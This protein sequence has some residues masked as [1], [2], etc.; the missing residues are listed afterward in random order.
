MA[1][2]IGISHETGANLV[3]TLERLSDG[4]FWNEVSGAWQAAPTFADKSIALT[5]GSSENS[6]HYT[7]ANTGSLGTP[8]RV[9]VRVHDDGDTNNKTIAS[10]E[11]QVASGDEVLDMEAISG[12]VTAANNLEAIL[13]GTGANL[14]VN[15][16]TVTTNALPWNATWDAEVQSECNDALVAYDPPTKAEM[17][18]AFTEIKGATW[19]SSTDTLEAIRDRGDVAWKTSTFSITAAAIADQVWDELQSGHTGAG[20]FGEIA[21][22]IAAILADTGTDGVV[23]SAATMNAVADALLDRADGVEPASAGTERTLREALRIIL[24][25]VAGKLSGAAGST[26]AIRDTNDSKDRISA[27][28]DAD[29]NRT[30]VTLDD[31]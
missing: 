19:S 16:F 27:T 1:I 20:T 12:D 6:G 23:L 3:A 2:N 31:T 5:E 25:A 9:R 11:I 26:V 14:T 15:T 28:V 21:T 10:A 22:E 18:S 8:G 30:A 7:G 4:N 29:G 17:D 24:S 13:D